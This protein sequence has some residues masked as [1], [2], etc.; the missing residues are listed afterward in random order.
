MPSGAGMDAA[1]SQLNEIQRMINLFL[2]IAQGN[3]NLSSEVFR[4]FLQGQGPFASS[5]LGANGTESLLA[6]LQQFRSGLSNPLAGFS[7]PPQMQGLFDRM[8]FP[9][10]VLNSTIGAYGQTADTM[11]IR[12]RLNTIGN[13]L[14]GQQAAMQALADRVLGNWGMTGS[15]GSG[16]EAAEALIRNGGFNAHLENLANVGGSIVNQRGYG[17]ETQ[18]A[19]DFFS[20]IMANGGRDAGTMNLVN[21]GQGLINA[22]GMTPEMRQLNN[23]IVHGLGSGGSTPGLQDLI[24]R[25]ASLV[26]QGG[27]TPQMTAF[28]Q[29]INNGIASGGMTPESKQLFGKVMEIVNNGGRGGALLPME[30]V[31][32]MARDAAATRAQQSAEA[33][34]RSALQ[35]TGSAAFSGTTEQALGEFSDQ[36][37]QQ[38]AE[39]IRSGALTQQELQLKQLLGSMGVGSDLTKSAQALLGQYFGAGADLFKTAGANIGTGAQMML[40]GE[41]TIARRLA[42]YLGSGE[43]LMR[44]AAANIGTGADLMQSGESLAA[45][46]MGQAIGGFQDTIANTIARLNAATGM[47]TGAQQ[48]ANQRMGLGLSGINDINSLAFNN[49]F[50]AGDILGTLSNQNLE[51]AR[52]LTGL[53]GLEFSN[54]QNAYQSLAGL[55]GLGNTMFT[56]QQQMALGANAQQIDALLRSMGIS[57]DISNNF[58]TNWFNAGNGLTNIAQLYSSLVPSGMNAYGDMSQLLVRA[59]MQPGFWSQFGGNLL[60]GLVGG[61]TGGLGSWLTKGI[62]GLFGG[63]RGFNLG[64]L[65]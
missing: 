25:G 65:N 43:G 22:G 30:T 27:M 24:S 16:L 53:T 64:T 58:S 9:L 46:R 59:A 1:N 11:A 8:N 33:A 62:G 31:V 47:I 41:D 37:M 13:G 5:F 36:A 56:G 55:L 40:G 4:Q 63:G 48:G 35:R 2:G 39:A 49:Q 57:S 45:T 3:T 7:L 42:A 51:A 23:Y 29:D 10:D 14:T 38:E 6:Q 15:M 61:L 34:R 19:M 50:R 18:G 17:P 54:N 20:N 21:T 52:A 60:N 26:G 28:L 32:S 12:D 44:S